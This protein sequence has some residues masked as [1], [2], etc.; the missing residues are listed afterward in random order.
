MR[1][2]SGVTTSHAYSGVGTYQVTLVVT[3]DAG[4][5]AQTNQTLTVGSAGQP[6]ASFTFLP[7][8][9]RV[10][11]QVAFDATGSTPG[12]GATIRSYKWN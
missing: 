3:D 11:Q 1:T 9:P 6:S 10:N 7:S 5:T 2:G 8:G 4:T 12:T